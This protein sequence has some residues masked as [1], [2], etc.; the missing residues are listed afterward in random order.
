MRA[1]RA[2]LEMDAFIV[3]RASGDLPAEAQPRLD[4]HLAGCERCRGELAGYEE[5]LELVRGSP[6]SFPLEE[7]GRDLASSTLRRWRRD[8]RGRVVR[9]AVVAGTLAVAAAAALTLAPGLHGKG[10]PQ[11]ARSE[12][13][14][15]SW[16]PDVDGALEASGL[17]RDLDQDEE[18]GGEMSAV[19]VVLAAFDAVEPE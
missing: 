3:E 14:V 8:R 10:T 13:L 12:V 7:S 4:V 11:P 18:M 15:A 2:C 9:V 16:E 17:R 5:V 19:D 6:A 1:E